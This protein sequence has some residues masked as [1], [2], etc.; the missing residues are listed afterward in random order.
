MDAVG[1]REGSREVGGHR[2]L[3]DDGLAG[4]DA[5]AGLH[6][7]AVLKKATLEGCQTQCTMAR[8]VRI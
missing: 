3:D 5:L 8:Y 6:E 2:L 4:F 1:V 7:T